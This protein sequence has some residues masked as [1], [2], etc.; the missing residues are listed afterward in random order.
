MRVVISFIAQL[1]ATLL[2]LQILSSS[3]LIGCWWWWRKKCN[4]DERYLSF[5]N[6]YK[7]NSILKSNKIDFL[8]MKTNLFKMSRIKILQN[9]Q[10]SVFFVLKIHR[11]FKIKY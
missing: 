11:E 3:T 9:I 7:I 4:F 6:P 10:I 5:K 2:I 8:V 1:D